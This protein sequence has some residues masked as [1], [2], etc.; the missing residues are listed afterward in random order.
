MLW[1]SKGTSA[2][3]L[4][5][6]TIINLVAIAVLAV[7]QYAMLRQIGVMLVRLGPGYARPLR[8][9]PRQGE[10]LGLKF[11]ALWGDKGQS[12]P[13]LYIFVSALCPICESVRRAC[14]EVAPHWLGVV[15]LVFIYE[16]EEAAP[17]HEAANVLIWSH[18]R[19]MDELEIRLVP[20][21]V[22]TDRAAT[23]VAAG[24]ISNASQ[25]ESLLE[26]PQRT[27]SETKEEAQNGRN[28]VL[29]TE[30]MDVRATH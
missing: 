20:Y 25:L 2:V 6:L 22:M 8:Q 21:G 16:A 10:Y 19:L 24:L 30:V 1:P 5:T 12:L 3:I 9:G 13:T 7:I 26:I 11:G 18:P 17:Q 27:I 14:K 15:D 4:W 23:T 28:R 29:K